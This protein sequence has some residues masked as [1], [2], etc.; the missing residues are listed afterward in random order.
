[1][2]AW[3]GASTVAS[4]ALVSCASAGDKQLASSTSQ[5]APSSSAAPTTSQAPATSSAEPTSSIPAPPPAPPQR[6]VREDI[7]TLMMVGVSNYDDARQA[8]AAG[9]GGLFIGSWTDP[10]LITEPGRNIQ[11]LRQEF[12]RPF[13]VA[14]DAEG[15]RVVR[16]SGLFGAVPAPRVMAQT[17][18]PEQ[19]QATGF[20][21]GSKLF[22]A[23][24]NVDFAPVLD[25]DSGPAD[26]AIG[27]RSFSGDPTTAATF[28]TAF[29]R[30]LLDAGVTPVFKHFPGHGRASGDSHYAEVVTPP[31]QSLK[32]L[33]LAPYAQALS[34]PG[35]AV[36]VGHMIVPDYGDPAL[37]STLDPAIYQLLR[38]G[39]YPGG[40]PFGGV[41][42]TDDLSGMKAISDLMGPAQAAE[43]AIAAGADVALWITTAHLNQAIDDVEAAVADGRIPEDSIR[44]RA[45]KVRGENP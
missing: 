36:M 37:P 5:V 32:D 20:E 9:V 7:A 42:Y 18:T 17:M 33:D 25:V 15:G 4:L 29:G 19:V 3:V 31:I 35:A 45:A 34:L 23:G 14:I 8:L 13:N 12:P 6:P 27:D 2:V 38:S 39:D 11:A 24:I 43:A 10:A 26:G 30:G 28:A 40:V 41:V 44:A 16:Q 1:M 21:L 22:A